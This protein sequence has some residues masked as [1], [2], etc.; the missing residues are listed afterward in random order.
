M[1]FGQSVELFGLDLGI[2]IARGNGLS[3]C[4]SELNESIIRVVGSAC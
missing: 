3:C 2:P 4:A 1:T